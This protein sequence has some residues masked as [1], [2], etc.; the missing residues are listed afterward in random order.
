MFLYM[1]KCKFTS[2]LLWVLSELDKRKKNSKYSIVIEKL[3]SFL[4]RFLITK[5][6]QITSLFVYSQSYLLLRAIASKYQNQW[7]EYE[8]YTNINN[9]RNNGVVC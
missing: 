7:Y 8:K 1:K 5:L 6:R 3:E 9:G 4:K 2:K